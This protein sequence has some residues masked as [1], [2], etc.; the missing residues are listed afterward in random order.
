MMLMASQPA[1]AVFEDGV[2]V[3][4]GASTQHYQPEYLQVTVCEPCCTE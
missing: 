3:E 1:P 2:E 4:P